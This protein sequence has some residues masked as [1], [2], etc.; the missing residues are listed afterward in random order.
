MPDAARPL[1]D[2]RIATPIAVAVVEHDDRVLIGQRPPG[3]V[4]GG[5]WEFP[6]GKIF[7]G[8]SAEEAAVRECRE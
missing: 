3:V 7:E 5:L 4:L 8:E 2:S 1:V 6:G